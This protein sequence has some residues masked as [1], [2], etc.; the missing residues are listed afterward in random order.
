M[1]HILVV[2]DEQ[3]MRH[4]LS[5]MLEGRGYQV[6]QAGDGAEA[7]EMI[8]QNDYHM[9]ITDIKMPR[10]NGLELL[11]KIR[12]LEIPVV[13][14]TAFATVDSAVEAMQLGAVDYITKPFEEDRILLTVE[15]TVRLSKLMSENKELRQ[16]LQKA[17][18]PGEV[19]H[20][21]DAMA[22]VM[23]L[24]SRVAKSDSAVLISGASGTGKELISRYIHYHSSRGANRFV[25]V[26]CAAI[27]PNLVESELF[28]HEKGSFTG[29]DRRTEGKFEYAA[30]GTLFLDEIGDLPIEAQ[31]KLLRA[32]QEKK[33]Q[34]VGGN[35]EI[36][37]DVRVIC[38]TNRKL[39]ELV[40]ADRFRQ[41]LFFRINVFPIQLP[42]LKERTDDIV[43]LAEYFLK[44]L[45]EPT[46]VGLDETARKSLQAYSWPGNVRELAN[47]MERA[48]ILSGH[49]GTITGKTLSFLCSPTLEDPEPEA[50][51]LPAK[52]IDLEA[53]ENDLIQ[54]AL[55][56][57]GNN[58]SEAARLLGVTRAKF[59]TLMK[60]ADKK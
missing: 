40:E 44:R 13:F 30:G 59:R 21:S 17:E 58:Q 6:S 3:R 5:L 27:S 29:A 41:D 56:K 26:N 25:P 39:V 48:A 36:P 55:D 45:G 24:A 11:E 15:R 28:G 54:Q 19:V 4:L 53:L 31:A 9:V 52:G 49:S 22:S 60:Q 1:N 34:R 10:M 50:F 18:E 51:R 57:T 14:I 46:P 8:N 7:L 2:D 20:V 12:P 23:D 47:A 16:K 33:I 35:Q 42:T 38:A 32:L 43:P 37:V